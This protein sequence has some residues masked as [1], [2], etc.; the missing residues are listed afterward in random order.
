[1]TVFTSHLSLSMRW[2]ATSRS[3]GVSGEAPVSSVTPHNLLNTC[4]ETLIQSQIKIE[5]VVKKM[6][7][8]FTNLQTPYIK[9]INHRVE[10]NPFKIIQCLGYKKKYN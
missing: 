6:K 4:N 3:T 1:M 8:R 2:R 7:E 10:K 9:N 5:T